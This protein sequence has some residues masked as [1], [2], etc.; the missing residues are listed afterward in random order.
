MQCVGI[1]VG[2]VTV[3]IAA[4]DG[5]QASFQVVHHGGQPLEVVERIWQ[6]FPAGTSFGV[7]GHLGHISEVAATE[8]ALEYVGGGF[9]AVA[10][11]GGE[12]FAVYMLQ[13]SRIDGVLTHNQCAAG[14]GAFFIQQIGRLGLGLDEAVERSFQGAVVPLAS[15]C[16][17]HCKSDITH[18]LNRQEAR[19]E[20]ILRTLH[21]TMANK[22]VALV[23]QAGR[24]VEQLLLVGGLSRNRALTA[25]LR[26]KLPRVRVTVLPE[27]PCFEAL[28]AALLARTEPVHRRP[29]LKAPP[30]LETLPPLTRHENQVRVIASPPWSGPTTG[31]FVL[32][33]DAGSTTTKAVL[34][35]PGTRRIVASHYGRT[36]GDP[37]GATRQCLRALVE[38]LGNPQAILAGTT[39]SARQLV[40]AYL[41]TDHVYNEISAHAVG[42]AHFDP[43]VD[44]IFEIGGQ[45]SKYI[46]LRNGVAI[47]YAMNAACS[48]GTGSFLEE[49]AQGDLGLDLA[50]IAEVALSAEAPVRFK[51]TCAAF[52][53]S[54][55]RAALQEGHSR[56]NVAAGLVYSIV[57]NYLDKV[58]CRRAVG[59]KVFIQGGVALNRAVAHA[60]TQCIGKPI[61][62][63]PHPELLGALGVALL[64]LQRS[65]GEPGDVRDLVALAAPALDVLGEFDCRGCGNRCKIARFEVAGRRFPF[66]GR[67]SRFESLGKGKHGRAGPVDLV[68]KRNELILGGAIGPLSRVPQRHDRERVRVRAGSKSALASYDPVHNALT[69]GHPLAGPSPG[70]AETARGR[71]EP[72]GIPR[73][74]TAHWLYPLYATFFRQL[75]LEPV[76]SGIDPEGWLK[77]RAAFCFPVQIAHGAVLDLVRHGVKTVFLPHV[78]RVPGAAA[79]RDSQL[80]PITQASP[81]YIA[82]A[83]PEATFLSPLL[84]F[85][86]GYAASGELVAMAG[87]QLGFSKAAAEAA[88][89]EAVRAQVETE[90]ALG[91]LG[92]DALAAAEE[93]GK[94]TVI[95]VGRGYNAFPTEASQS[96]ARK[97]FSMGVRVIPGDCLPQRAA[98]PTLWHFPNQIMN[99]VE[100]VK[101]HGNLFLACVSNFSCTIDAFLHSLLASELGTKP[102]LVLEI[103][104]HTAGAGV[105]TR[106]EAFLD[107]IENYR[108]KPAGKRP[109]RAATVGADAMITTSAGQ[110]VPLTDRRARLYFPTFSHYHAKAAALNATWLGLN[111]GR[112]VELDRRHL[113]IGLQ[114]T[115][116]RECLPLPIVIGQMLE[117]HRSREPGE[118]VGFYVLRGGP[119]CAVDCYLDYFS[120]FI[121]EN[122]L[123]DL[124]LFDPHKGNNYYGLSLRSL[125]QF[126]APVV[127]LADIF[128]EMEQSLRVVGGP[129][130]REL[131]RD[132]WARYVDSAPSLKALKANLEPLIRRIARIPHA[133]AAACP[134]VMVTGDFFTRLSPSF[135]ADVHDL[136]ARRG[137]ILVPANFGEQLLCGAYTGMADAAGDWGAPPESF[138][139]A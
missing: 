94:P 54:D 53:N 114:H 43:E 50:E 57:R 51:A 44:T 110:R 65:R 99:A 12:V 48:A 136:Y 100:L 61:V 82:K 64:T 21:D 9:D 26:E 120:R 78:N 122:E 10:S 126:Y 36:N 40:G 101:R 45:D 46:F 59:K 67:C 34:L 119:P 90:Q 115:S 73:A 49:C 84:N 62:I 8:A 69:P 56:E 95:L 89:R 52:I 113:E 118:I 121:R 16:S 135:M 66:G 38:Q 102:Y 15:R 107:V 27:S 93:A 41:G 138:R 128:A 98:G 77:T 103:D 133:D 19:V 74:L 55:I 63:P 83:F 71:G 130:S 72:I 112:P 23:E 127:A 76:L 28:G 125:E 32:G 117:A 24:P 17:V 22:V 124:F 79:G 7:S 86:R 88:Y 14:S 1:N 18:M 4:L 68:E 108:P 106:L 3:K 42:A 137:I 60:F 139:A 91:R 35:H 80:C 105:Q 132:C 92:A 11:L 129:G 116:G 123:E 39:G 5:D 25:A 87:S 134:K 97:L 58:K 85:A 37:L 33:V 96:A 30:P 81:Y 2:A 111:M 20:D 131:L 6:T 109:F 70:R 75:G 13:G 104:A 47:D 31:P 29:K